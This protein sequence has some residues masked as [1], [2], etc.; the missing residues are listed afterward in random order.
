MQFE[1]ASP[2]KIL[3]NSHNYLIS[4][5][6]LQKIRLEWRIGIPIGHVEYDGVLGI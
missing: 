6:N 4:S 5:N 2:S 3:E 1:I